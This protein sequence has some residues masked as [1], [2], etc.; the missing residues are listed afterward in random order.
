MEFIR[1]IGSNEDKDVDKLINVN[2]II[3]VVDKNNQTY[4]SFYRRGDKCHT[5]LK[6]S[7]WNGSDHIEVS[8]GE[9]DWFKT[10]DPRKTTAC[11]CDKYK[12]YK[13]SRWIWLKDKTTFSTEDSIDILIKKIEEAKVDTL[14]PK[15]EVHNHLHGDVIEHTQ[16]N[17]KDSVMLKN[18]IVGVKDKLISFFKKGDSH[19]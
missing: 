5:C 15:H 2:N 10:L 18:K 3:E 14:I 16:L 19:E 1:V 8:V 6:R 17:V 13:G 7:Y 9:P 12:E 11:L 4:S